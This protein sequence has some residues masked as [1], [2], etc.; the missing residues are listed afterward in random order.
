MV[1]AF[2]HDNIEQ[3]VNVGES[4]N[5][6]AHVAIIHKVKLSKLRKQCDNY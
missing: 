6:P 3:I 4:E 2:V 1:Q 5:E